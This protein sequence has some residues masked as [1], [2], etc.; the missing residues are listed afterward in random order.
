M[1][2]FWNADERERER[3]ERKER[4][5]HTKGTKH[6]IDQKNPSLSGE[7]MYVKIDIINRLSKKAILKRHTHSRVIQAFRFIHRFVYKRRLYSL[8]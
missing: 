5:H 2:K 3:E 4:V 6:K 8:M 1:V 7:A